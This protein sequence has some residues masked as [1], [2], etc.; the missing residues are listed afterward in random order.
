LPRRLFTALSALS[1]LLCV[2]VVPLWLRSFWHQDRIS[3]ATSGEEFYAVSAM[4]TI[5]F[6]WHS[7]LKLTEP[8]LHFNSLPVLSDRLPPDYLWSAGSFGMG[9]DSDL[10]PIKYRHVFMPCWCSRSR[11]RC[12]PWRCSSAYGAD[13]AEAASAS[14]SD[15]ATMSAPPP[16]AARSAVM[17]LIK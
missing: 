16:A 11:S 1:L 9:A 15:A 2:A 6:L 4:G 14:V 10:A 12:S 8:G 17:R 5:T 3:V 13:A 7:N